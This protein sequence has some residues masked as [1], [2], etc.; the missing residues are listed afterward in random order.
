M[1]VLKKLQHKI[2]QHQGTTNDEQSKKFPGLFNI[3]FG[4]LH[5]F[6]N[7]G[8]VIFNHPIFYTIFLKKKFDGIHQVKYS[9]DYI[10]HWIKHMK[11]SQPATNGCNHVN[12]NPQPGV[13]IVKIYISK[14]CKSNTEKPI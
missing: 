1:R 8:L 5:T 11:G 7:A 4:G 13:A 6:N 12:G 3:W 10:D 2:I 9:C 14:P